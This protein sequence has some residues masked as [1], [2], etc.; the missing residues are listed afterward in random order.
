MKKIF[1]TT[2]LFAVSSIFFNNLHAHDDDKMMQSN[3]LGTISSLFLTAPASAAVSLLPYINNNGDNQSPNKEIKVDS[4]V[5][6]SILRNGIA[7][8]SSIK[9]TNSVKYI[10]S[11]EQ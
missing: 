10:N 9:F 3:I 2:L 6:D 1:L 5:S 4:R 11:L 7:D 8:S